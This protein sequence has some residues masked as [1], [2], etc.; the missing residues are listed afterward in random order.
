MLMKLTVN[1]TIANNLSSW[2]SWCSVVLDLYAVF[3]LAGHAQINDV[4]LINLDTHMHI[5]WER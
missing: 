3:I 4:V 5:C 2:C 1:S